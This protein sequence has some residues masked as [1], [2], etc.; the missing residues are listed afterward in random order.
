MKNLQEFMKTYYE[1][2]QIKNLEK[3]KNKVIL[4]TGASG[5]I[6]SNLTAFFNYLNDTKKLNIK[7]I[8][9]TKSNPVSWMARSK[10]ITYLKTDLSK[11]FLKKNFQ[12]DYL[13]H[14]ATY[15]Q[16]KKFLQHPLETI[17]LN[18]GTLSRLLDL[19]K[20]NK[21]KVAYLS[22]AEIYGEADK[23]H[24][25]TDESFF[26]Y[27]NTLSDRAIY[28]ESKRLAETIC[29]L[30]QKAIPVKITRLLICYGPGV[31]SDDSR[32]YSEFIKKAQNNHSI[33]MM[34]Q[35]LAQRTFCFV[36]DAIEMLLNVLINGKE[37]VYNIAGTGTITIRKLAEMI[38]RINNAK[39]SS[40]IKLAEIKGTPMRSTLS[41]KRYIDEFHK[42]KFIS[43]IEG[44]TATSRWFTNLTDNEPKTT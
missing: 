35:G 17:T 25:P 36:T 22:S 40:K 12:F 27:V 44:M 13:I 14:C 38:A 3:L 21:A 6:G 29:Y 24:I 16:P 9:I 28:A 43:L 20:K 7:I 33:V 32:V 42:K 1:Y 31:K 37:T 23:K 5:L 26:G 4:I 2:I 39:V 34:D 41:N 11:R 30:Y 8:A 15:G 18:I 19:A 10:K